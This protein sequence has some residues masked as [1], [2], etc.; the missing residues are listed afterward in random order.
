MVVQGAAGVQ[1]WSA[2]FHGARDRS[3]SGWLDVLVDSGRGRSSRMGH[4]TKQRDTS[5][6][7]PVH[8]PECPKSLKLSRT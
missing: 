3:Y 2:S 8:T 5:R 6:Q 7:A 4:R 1:L